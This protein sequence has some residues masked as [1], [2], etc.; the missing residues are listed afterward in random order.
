MR[1]LVTGASGQLGSYLLRR[2]RGTAD[3]AGWSGTRPGELFGV[4]LRPVDLADAGAV[5]EAFRQDRPDVVVHAAALARVAD[6]HRDPDR[7]TRVNTAGTALLADLAA[8]AGARLVYVSTDLVFDGERGWYREDDPPAPLSVYG[9]SK[10]DA[11][12]AVLAVLRGVVVRVSLLFGPSLS[13]RPT[14]FDEQ[15]AAL[16]AGRPV[17]L[18]ADEWRTPLGLA[19]AAN[20]LITVASSDVTGLLHV[21]GPE[22]LSRLDMGRRLAAFLG[23]DPSGIVAVS[24]EQ[25]AATEPR[26]RDTSLDCGRWRGLFPGLPWP[27]WEDALREMVP[28]GAGG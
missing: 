25:A 27:A 3:V 4:P 5:A 21:G 28:A 7:A 18:F 19:A 16:R 14:F 2:L 9:R 26:P 1:I 17:T 20:A 24:R 15:V 6:C 13:G 23:A 22:R 8:A 10:A 12:A 11:E